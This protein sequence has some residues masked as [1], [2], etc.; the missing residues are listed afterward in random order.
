MKKI[1]PIAVALLIVAG[2]TS[3]KKDYTCTCKATGKTDIVIPISKAKKSDA[4]KTCDAAKTTYSV[5]G[6]SCSL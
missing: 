6:Y 2:M 1:A 3:C 5:A 4:T